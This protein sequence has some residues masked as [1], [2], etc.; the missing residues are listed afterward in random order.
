MA[1]KKKTIIHLIYKSHASIAIC[2]RSAINL[3]GRKYFLDP[4]TKQ[5]E[6]FKDERVCYMCKHIHK[7]NLTMVRQ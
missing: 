6:L 7:H 5:V 3:F 2:G 4:D 1:K